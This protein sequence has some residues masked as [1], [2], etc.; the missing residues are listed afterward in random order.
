MRLKYS[1]VLSCMVLSNTSRTVLNG[2]LMFVES[3]NVDSKVHI[4]DVSRMKLCA[5]HLSV[6]I[7]FIVFTHLYIYNLDL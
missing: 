4:S 5:H 7:A 3:S 2:W 6:C 1:G